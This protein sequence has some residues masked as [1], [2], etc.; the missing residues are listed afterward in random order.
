MGVEW[1]LLVLWSGGRLGLA[2]YRQC[3]AHD[4]GLGQHHQGLGEHGRQEIGHN[5]PSRDCR[6]RSL[7]TI[8]LDVPV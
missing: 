8:K 1:L 2:Q 3:D 5:T 6:S 4:D 7:M